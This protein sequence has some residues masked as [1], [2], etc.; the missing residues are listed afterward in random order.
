M[1]FLVE[2]IKEI[3]LYVRKTMNQDFL[4]MKEEKALH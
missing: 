2:P 1:L 4:Q 3:H